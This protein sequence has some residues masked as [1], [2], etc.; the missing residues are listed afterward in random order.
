MHVMVVLA[1]KKRLSD[2]ELARLAALLAARGGA[3]T[4][5]IE[6]LDG[7]LTALVI[8]PDVVM[9][10]EYLP[11]VWGKGHEP[12]FDSLE[13]AQELL[14]L[15]MR[16]WNAIIAELDAS[17]LYEM[18]LD[19]PDERG[20]PGR[21]W[22]GGFMQGV[23]M[24]RAQWAPM[25]TDEREGLLATIALVA[26][27]IDPAYPTEPLSPEMTEKLTLWM[28]AA[29]PRAYARFKAERRG[30]GVSGRSAAQPVRRATAKVGRNEP[31]PCGSGRKY[32]QCCGMPDGR[33][34]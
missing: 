25:L 26:G 27:E 18:L 23:A 33:L 20:V 16:H 11:V 34:H 8:G 1:G 24:R 19:E 3:S 30:G 32:K 31:C 28:A 17:D 21:Q 22:A 6:R 10:S 7:F 13:E 29:V 12:E 15:L 4:M 9:P 14:G 2:A 5:N